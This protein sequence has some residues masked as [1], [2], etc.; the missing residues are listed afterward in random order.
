MATNHRRKVAYC[1]RLKNRAITVLIILLVTTLFLDYL[2]LH[3]QKQGVQAIKTMMLQGIEGE[4][5]G[6]CY[7]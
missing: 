7:T 1:I 6:N 5:Y 4:A 2:R 3:K